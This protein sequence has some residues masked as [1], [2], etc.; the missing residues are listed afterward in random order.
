MLTP[1]QIARQ[2][3]PLIGL[4]ARQALAN[5]NYRQKVYQNLIDNGMSSYKARIQSD[6]A[7]VRYASKQ[8]RQRAESIVHTELAFAYNRGAHEGILAAVDAR[9]MNHCEMVWTTAGTNRVCSRCLSLKDH[10]IGRTDEQGVQLPPLHPRCRCTI[11]YREIKPVSVGGEIKQ[12][13]PERI[14]A[15]RDAED[16][17]YRAATDADFGFARLKTPPDWSREILL[18]NGDGRGVER[19]INCQRCV[20]AHEARMRGYDVVA[21][22]SWGFNDPLRKVKTLLAV[23]D[24]PEVYRCA[25]KTVAEVEKFIADKMSAWGTGVRAFVWFDRGND[26]RLRNLG[27][28]IVAQLNENGFV[29][30]GDPQKRKLGAVRCLSEARLDSVKIMRVDDLQFTELVKRCCMNREARHDA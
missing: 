3:R 18:T 23:F 15:I 16:K 27:H 11:Q 8:I 28:I 22:P 7:A 5:V 13:T 2:V 1:K 4:T 30:F 29:N 19:L 6:K 17:A 20:V 9:L 12:L 24:E 25:G 26:I 21:R 14:K 10:V